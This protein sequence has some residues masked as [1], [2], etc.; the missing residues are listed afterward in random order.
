MRNGVVASLLVAALLA[1][2]GAG[3]LVGQSVSVNR[4]FSTT[5]SAS[6]NCEIPAEGEVILQVLNSTSGKPISS[7][8]I[9]GQIVPVPCG[10]TPQATITLN[11]TLTN[12]TG[13]A[14]FGD[15][16]GEYHLTLYSYGNYF[17][18]ASTL[19][20]RTTCVSLSIPS[21]ETVITYSPTFQFAC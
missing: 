14:V 15:E 19:P 18:D 7:A 3:Y 17:V 1:G 20:E 16:L 2:A 11:T 12:D 5:S 21:G 13:F 6:T 10:S 8:P 9:Q 4:P